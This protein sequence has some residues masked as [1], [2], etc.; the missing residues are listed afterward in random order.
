[1]VAVQNINGVA[2]VIDP[3]KVIEVI[4]AS[5]GVALDDYRK[6]AQDLANEGQQIDRAAAAAAGVQPGAVD[7]APNVAQI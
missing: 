4:F 3:Q 2:N 7:V 5:N 6:S 1:M